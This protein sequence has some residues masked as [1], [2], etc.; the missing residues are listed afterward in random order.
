VRGLLHD[1]STTFEGRHFTLT[2]ARNEP[3]PVQA[4]V[5]I[6]VGGGGERRTL[7]IAAMHA[8]GWNLPF[9]AAETFA[10]KRAVL[11]EHCAAVGRDPSEIRCAV[12][13]GIARDEDDL[14]AQFGNIREF[15]RPGVV[16][17]TG[18]ALADRVREYVAAG[19]DQ[20]NF[21]VRAPF[22]VGVLEQAAAALGLG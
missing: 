11:H 13:V 19:A 20:V 15:V 12:N 6:W 10:H 18:A 8:D 21:A 14:A 1:D 3:R 17:G 5:P 9:V 16:I 4:A 2:D 22:D 7:R